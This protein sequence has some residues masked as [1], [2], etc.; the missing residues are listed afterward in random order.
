M[1]T[2]ICTSSYLVSPDARG[3]ANN[4]I[5]YIENKRV[6]PWN[7]LLSSNRGVEL[8]FNNM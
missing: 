6:P 3:N 2:S 4:Y 5:K 1:T 8:E 7:G